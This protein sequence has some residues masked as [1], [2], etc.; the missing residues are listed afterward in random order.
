MFLI[1]IL[2]KM[3]GS[4]WEL[5]YILM[6]LC[7]VYKVSSLLMPTQN[8]GDINILDVERRSPLYYAR[9]YGH[10]DISNILLANSCTE[11]AS[12]TSV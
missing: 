6:C 12:D 3:G 11:E 8:G 2:N 5:G 10:Q 1:I 4:A 9:V 7:A